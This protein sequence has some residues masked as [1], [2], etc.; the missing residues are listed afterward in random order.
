TGGQTGPHGVPLRRRHDAELVDRAPLP[1]VARDALA[2]LAL[3]GAGALGLPVHDH[4]GVELTVKDLAH[5]ADRPALCRRR[6][7]LFAAKPDRDALE[8]EPLRVKIE[9]AA[10]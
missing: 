9:H 5:G 7:H 1:L 6:R 2:V 10:D 8:P 4:A 3:V